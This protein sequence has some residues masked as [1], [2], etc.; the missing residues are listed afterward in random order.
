[1]FVLEALLLTFMT[2]PAV[3][4]LY[5]PELRK[6]V[7]A[8]GAA[9]D[10]VGD[11]DSGSPDAEGSSNDTLRKSSGYSKTRFT[12]VLDRLE[13]VPGLMA[14]TQL[15]QP[16]PSSLTH[17]NSV[18]DV[19]DVSVE[20]LRLIELS[21]RTSAV[22]KSS[23]W[24][25]L[26]RT[27]PL[28]G[29]FRT[30]GEL[31]GMAVSTSLAVV[32]YDDLASSVSEIATRKSSQLVLIPWL[33]PYHESYREVPSTPAAENSTRLMN[34]F[35]NLFRST[36]NDSSHSASALHSHFVRTVFAQSKTDVAL[37][38]DQHVT[39]EATKVTTAASGTGGRYHLFLPFFGGP[40]DR[41]A[42]ELVI[43]FC[44]HPTVS[45]TVV[46]IM[47]Q[48]ID[49]RSTSI[50]KPPPVHYRSDEN[51]NANDNLLT[52]ASVSANFF[53][54]MSNRLDEPFFVA[55]CLP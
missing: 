31:N 43:R 42:L 10:H 41:L 6:R 23:A 8:T 15:L 21:D 13:H 52:V 33:P 29:I 32:T 19:N 35:D 36:H 48:D 46:R 1:M 27:D 17:E 49:L 9:F 53:L 3:V 54:N 39:E 16:P 34:P 44:A 7:T 18:D 47:R 14:L 4:L 37:Y 55:N 20:A 11:Q 22:M 24:D 25:T 26:I 5:P 12:V 50:E 30:F 28:L 2:T 45:A 40:D 38:V 51:A